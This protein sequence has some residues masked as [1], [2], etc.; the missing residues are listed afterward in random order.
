MDAAIKIGGEILKEA[1]GPAADAIRKIME[2]PGEQK[3]VR[4]ALRV[5]GRVANVSNVTLTGAAI[6]ART[7]N[8][9]PIATP[10]A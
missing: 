9:D 5:F 8:I 2:G 3:T 4:E 6:D 7:I 1:A 10:E